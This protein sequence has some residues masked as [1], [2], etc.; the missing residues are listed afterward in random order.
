LASLNADLPEVMRGIAARPLFVMR[1]DVRPLLITGMTPG[2]FRRVG[3]VPGGNF[4]GD[5]LSGSVL[6][7]GAD[8]QTVRTDGAT[9]LNVRLMLKTSDAALIGMSYPGIRHGPPEIIARLE[10]G[11]AVDP[12]DY[13]FRITPSF[14][15][16]APQYDWINRI[17][18]VG[19][20]YRRTDGP[21]YSIFELL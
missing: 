8:W 1:L 16:S 21:V 5:R 12:S 15:T 20:G 2:G 13:Y 17:V 14:E 6:D 7:G 10:K 19:I 3:M 4:E 9:T 18:A 11:E